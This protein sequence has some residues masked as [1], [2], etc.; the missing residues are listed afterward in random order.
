MYIITEFLLSGHIVKNKQN[1]L[2]SDQTIPT[3]STNTLAGL[4]F[5]IQTSCRAILHPIYWQLGILFPEVMS[6]EEADH[7]HLVPSLECM[8]NHLHAP[9]MPQLSDICTKDQNKQLT[10]TF[11]HSIK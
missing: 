10:V 11:Y 7:L 4:C 9:Y 6:L 5:H 1:M 2:L 3:F 8:T